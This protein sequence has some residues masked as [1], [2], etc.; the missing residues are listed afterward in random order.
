MN[1]HVLREPICNYHFCDTIIQSISNPSLKLLA[2][3]ISS[4]PLHFETYLDQC[5]DQMFFDVVGLWETRLDDLIC[6]LYNINNYSSHFQNRNTRGSGVAIFLHKQFQSLSLHNICLKLPHLE[7]LFVIVTQ[8]FRFIVRIIYRPPNAKVDEVLLSIEYIVESLVGEN[9]PYYIMGDFNI[10]LLSNENKVH[11]FINLLY[12]YYF[13][14]TIN[15]P[16]KV[17]S[18]SASLI[19]NIWTSNLHNHQVSGIH[20]TSI[21]DNFRI[22]SIFSVENNAILQS[23]TITVTKRIYNNLSIESFKKDLLNY[24][25]TSDLDETHDVN[26]SFDIY[27]KSF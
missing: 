1:D 20:Y 17:T 19:D 13:F 26:E 25:W 27:M 6:S 9:L 8:P 2:Y 7:F 11:D 23:S 3:N 10:N 22:I 4:V 12:S 21:S 5:L 14:P 18:T 15:K 16:T 24:K